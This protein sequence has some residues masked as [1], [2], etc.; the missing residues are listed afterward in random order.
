LYGPFNI[1]L[2]PFFVS[3]LAFEFH[4]IIKHTE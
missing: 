1:N 4:L 2:C 3:Y